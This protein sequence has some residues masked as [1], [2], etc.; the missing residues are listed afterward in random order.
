MHPART[1]V[2]VLG[3]ESSGSK[4]IARVCA[5]VLGIRPYGEWN[6]VGWCA[7]GG[8]EVCHRSLPYGDPPR[9]PDVE[10]MI[11]EHRADHDIRFVLTTRDVTLSE[12]SRSRR[13]AKPAPQLREESRRARE[14]MAGLLRSEWPVFI[15]SYETF[16]FLGKDYLDRLYAFLGTA[17]DFMP[18][19]VD[20]NAPRIAGSDATRPGRR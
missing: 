17:S 16:M 7:G 5:H 6:A 1:C 4:L 10:S 15:W 2:I 20:G 8:H 14:I 18:D 3:P 9:F 12:M 13:F 11:A 19:L